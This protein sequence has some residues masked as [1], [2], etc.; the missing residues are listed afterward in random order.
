MRLIRKLLLATVMAA[1][2]VLPATVAAPKAQ[3][4][5]RTYYIYWRYNASTHWVYYAHTSC[6]QTAR[7][8]ANYL[9]A[10]YHVQTYIMVR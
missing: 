9:A 7:A 4:T 2:F 3:A 8:W 10:G 6:P 1:G 5:T